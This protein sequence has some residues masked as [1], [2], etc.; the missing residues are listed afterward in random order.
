MK[1]VVG[2]I[3]WIDDRVLNKYEGQIKGED[4]IKYYFN[5]SVCKDKPMIG[6]LLRFETEKCCAINVRDFICKV[7]A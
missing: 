4:G 5:Y 2:Q 7:E 3:L 6:Q 1:T